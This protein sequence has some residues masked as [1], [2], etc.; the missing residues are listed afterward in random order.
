MLVEDMIRMCKERG[1][2]LA[3]SGGTGTPLS[4]HVA[5]RARPVGRGRTECY[6]GG[7]K[8]IPGKVEKLQ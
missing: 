7:T 4:P 5:G 3:P 6:F 1:V 8:C 2:G